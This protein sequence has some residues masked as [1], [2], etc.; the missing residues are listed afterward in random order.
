MRRKSNNY[1]KIILLFTVMFLLLVVVVP[2]II[3]QL[4]QAGNGYKT[5]W[6]AKDVLSYFGT[7]LG[8][9]ATIAAVITTI[10]YGE[11]SRKQ[12]RKRQMMPLLDCKLELDVNHKLKVGPSIELDVIVLAW[13]N[14]R[15]INKIEQKMVNS[16][17][18]KKSIYFEYHL[19]NVGSGNALLIKIVFNGRFLIRP[20]NIQPNSKEVLRIIVEDSYLDNIYTTIHFEAKYMDVDRS[21]FYKQEEILAIQKNDNNE[22]I[23]LN[24]SDRADGQK[25]IDKLEY[26][27]G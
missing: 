7:V 27:K 3:N 1:I 5:L 14:V 25:E 21:A 6:E 18:N 10:L 19:T 20:F 26:D 11:H 13:G 4:Y 2:I 16:V 12:D 22:I 24:V 23:F 9:V 8:A 15:S 17:K